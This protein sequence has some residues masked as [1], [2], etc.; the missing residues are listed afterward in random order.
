MI[1]I[2]KIIIIKLKN[3]LH[4][5]LSILKVK[6]IMLRSIK[7]RSIYKNVILVKYLIELI[8]PVRIIINIQE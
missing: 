6:K 7:T 8:N 3:K 5:I 2:I 1:K 4:N